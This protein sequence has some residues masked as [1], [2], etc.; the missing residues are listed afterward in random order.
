MNIP[1]SILKR[2]FKVLKRNTLF[3]LEFDGKLLEKKC[4][5]KCGK[6]LTLTLKGMYICRTRHI[7]SFA[8][9]ASKLA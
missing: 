9:K 7:P 1:D 3:P 5:P 2:K 6:K 4:C 8:I